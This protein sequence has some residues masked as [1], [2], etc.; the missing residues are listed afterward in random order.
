MPGARRRSALGRDGAGRGGE[1]RR[2]SAAAGR[3]P[4]RPFR[5]LRPGAVRSR[6]RQQPAEPPQPLCGV[7]A[8]R[9]RTRHPAVRPAHDRRGG[10]PRQRVRHRAAGGPAGRR[11]C[12]TS[13]ADPGLGRLPIG[14]FG[15]STGAAAALWAAAEPAADVAAVVSR[16]GR[17]DLAGPRLREVRAPTLLIVGGRDTVVL[18][19]NRQA[20]ARLR[21]ESRLE[22]VPGR[23][24]P[25]RGAG[26]AAGRRRAGPR[27]V[28]TPSRRPRDPRGEPLT[29]SPREARPAG[30]A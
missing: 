24:P 4:H 29:G 15:A 10:R 7:G 26:H 2:R 9:G 3:P 5:G 14:L 22:I 18:D 11:K 8:Q 28:P 23:D 30:A 21:C 20:Q 19:L 17:P 12:G 25:V 13:R 6:Q 1:G 16:G 27:L